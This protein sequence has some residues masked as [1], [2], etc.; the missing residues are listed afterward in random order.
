MYPILKDLKTY[1]SI[2]TSKDDSLLTDK[3]NQAI[4][5]FENITGQRKFVSDSLTTRIFY[6]NQRNVKDSKTFFFLD[7]CCFVQSL[8]INGN[9]INPNHYIV[10]DVNDTPLTKITLLNACPYNFTNY[11]TTEDFS[12][13]QI[14]GHWS[15]SIKCPVDVS[16][17]IIRL[18]AWL[19]NQKDNA[20]DYDK[21]VAFTMISKLPVGVPT[22]VIFTAQIYLRYF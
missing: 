15:Y 10:F 5:S 3:L 11:S 14:E 8:T 17:T 22:D 9:I 13:I 2:E 16:G 21:P 1:L 18:A 6:S 19:Y 12:T 7:D 4:L 20:A